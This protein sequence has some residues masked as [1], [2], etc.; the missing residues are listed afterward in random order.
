MSRE[1]RICFEIFGLTPTAWIVA[2]AYEEILINPGL[3]STD[4]GACELLII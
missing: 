1:L 4:R 3:Y 2:K